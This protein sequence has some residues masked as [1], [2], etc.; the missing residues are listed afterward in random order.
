[1][2][3]TARLAELVHAVGGA[4]FAADL[5][6]A[7][8][9]LVEHDYFTAFTIGPGGSDF[10][11][12]ADRAG[13]AHSV[14]AAEHYVSRWWRHDPEYRHFSAPR[15]AGTTS[16]VQTR[17]DQI[18]AGAYRTNCYEPGGIGDRLA[19]A[20]WRDGTCLTLRLYRRRGTRFRDRDERA[21]AAEAPLLGALCWE[22]RRRAATDDRPAAVLRR[23]AG[24]RG[25]ALSHRELV[26]LRGIVNNQSAEGIAIDLNVRPSTVVTYRQRGYAKL[27][28]ATRGELFALCLRH[29]PS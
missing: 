27:G 20:Y 17:L 28:I 13:T 19:L 22:H 2:R 15:P 21:L 5:H 24:A 3:H 25:Q 1:M 12:G 26:V 7:V 23:L 6:L 29:G 16:I 4:G 10:V 8:A 14:A 9:D 11:L 18:P